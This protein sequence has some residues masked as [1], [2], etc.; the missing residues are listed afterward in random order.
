MAWRMAGKVS[1][2]RVP[3]SIG[4]PAKAAAASGSSRTL[5]SMAAM[6]GAGTLEAG[7]IAVSRKPAGGE[8]AVGRRVRPGERGETV[9]GYAAEG[10]CR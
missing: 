6:L 2:D 8:S 4:K 3:K 5:T 1:S 10:F 9:E 7:M